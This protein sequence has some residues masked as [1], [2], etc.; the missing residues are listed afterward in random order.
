M[1]NKRNIITNLAYNYLEHILG[2]MKGGGDENSESP[3]SKDR[4]YN[5]QRKRDKI[6]HNMSPTQNGRELHKGKQFL[7]H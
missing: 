5:D 4:Q 1:L 7:L 6:L 2:N 3:N